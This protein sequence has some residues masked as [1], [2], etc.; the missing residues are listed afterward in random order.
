[1]AMLLQRIATTFAAPS[2]DGSIDHTEEHRD[3]VDAVAVDE[4]HAGNPA[5]ADGADDGVFWDK[6]V[7]VPKEVSI[8]GITTQGAT[9]S[10]GDSNALAKVF[11]GMKVAPAPPS[12]QPSMPLLTPQFLQQQASGGA[13]GG[14]VEGQGARLLQ[15]LVHSGGSSIGNGSAV[16]SSSD[17]MSLP[18]DK[19]SKLLRALS[20]NTAFCQELATEM[21]R[22]GLLHYD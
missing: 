19:V 12:V 7:K 1:M 2:E 13:S 14:G 9:T 21:Q 4:Y 20:N 6:K 17:G 16:G 8:P 11:A 22:A 18:K 10:D 3:D 15:S 5:D